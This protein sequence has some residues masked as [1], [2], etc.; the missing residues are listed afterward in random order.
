MTAWW[1][2]PYKLRRASLPRTIFHVRSLSYYWNTRHHNGQII[3]IQTSNTVHWLEG[4]DFFWWRR[5]TLREGEVCRALRQCPYSSPNHSFI[6]HGCICKNLHLF[7]SA[8]PGK[9]WSV[10][11][12]AIHLNSPWDRLLLIPC[13]SRFLWE[14]SSSVT[15]LDK[16]LGS[17]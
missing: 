1:R 7:I 2:E 12:A 17:W 14:A 16:Y 11:V 5:I 9:S 3:Q 13:S 4:Q 8:N 6:H 15:T 10:L